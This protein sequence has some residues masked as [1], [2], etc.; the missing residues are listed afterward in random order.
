MRRGKLRAVSRQA[1]A[2]RRA[3]R[4]DKT[5]E[6][7]S[8]RTESQDALPAEMTSTRSDSAGFL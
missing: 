4:R 8:C 1:E 2:W 3:F 5:S 7:V 6:A